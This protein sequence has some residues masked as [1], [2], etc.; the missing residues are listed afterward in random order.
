MPTDADRRLLNVLL[1][2]AL[3]SAFCGALALARIG[4][5]GRAALLFLGWN[6]VLAW[7]PLL[8]SLLIVRRHGPG[9]RPSRLGSLALGAVWLAFFPNAPYL[10]TDL[11]HLRAHGFVLLLYDA[12]MV[13]AFALTG[14]CIAFLSLWLIHRLVERRLGRTGGWAFVGAVAGLTGFGVFLGRFPRWN[15]WDLVTRPGE[16]FVTLA[17]HVQDP[18]AHPRAIG[19]TLMMA[20]LFVIA[21]LMFFV[22][23]SLSHEPRAATGTDD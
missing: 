23:T 3:A 7:V 10:V 4:L 8:M 11:I 21:Y 17:D 22:L 16:L 6:L 19:V 18:L 14:I 5:T 13:F 12:M 1:V 20:G 15:S 2:L 9:R